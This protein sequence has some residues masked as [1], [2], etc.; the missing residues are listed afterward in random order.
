MRCEGVMARLGTPD[1]TCNPGF[2][3]LNLGGRA[4]TSRE[5]AAFFKTSARPYF[6]L[7][8][9]VCLVVW[10]DATSG[11]SKRGTES[12]KG[13]KFLVAVVGGSH[14]EVAWVGEL[15]ILEESCLL[16]LFG[17]SWKS[18]V[19]TSCGLDGAESN[20]SVVSEKSPVSSR[21]KSWENRLRRPMIKQVLS[22]GTVLGCQEFEIEKEGP[23]R[24]PQKLHC[25]GSAKFVLFKPYMGQSRW[26]GKPAVALESV[27]YMP[28]VQNKGA[29][30]RLAASRL[31][32]RVEA[33]EC[34]H[35]QRSSEPHRYT[36]MHISMKVEVTHFFWQ[37]RTYVGESAVI[38]VNVVHMF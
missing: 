19:P 23:G 34:D 9:G 38:L 30:K 13:L 4:G 27:T 14:E 17:V 5:G 16:A 18:N 10:S 32:R 15:E 1:F 31:G 36:H 6:R 21:S 37:L 7:V 11:A 24:A 2:I 22:I 8:S 33:V 25:S 35:R 28:T 29:P 26:A 3:R 12:F 20:T